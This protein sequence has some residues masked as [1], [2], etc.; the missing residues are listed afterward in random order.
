MKWNDDSYQNLKHDIFEIL[1]IE[2][3]EK[4]AE[5][6]TIR[7]IFDAID[8]MIEKLTLRDKI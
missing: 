4:D 2:L 1:R 6:V 3:P 7:Q 5:K 8:E